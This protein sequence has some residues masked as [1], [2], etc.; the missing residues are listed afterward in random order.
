M[1]TILKSITQIIKSAIEKSKIQSKLNALI[2]K[3]KKSDY[4]KINIPKNH[5]KM[6]EVLAMYGISD[7]TQLRKTIEKSLKSN[8]VKQTRGE[9]NYY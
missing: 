5:A 1:K 4:V 9:E 2:A 3:Y 8:Y 7:E 6:L